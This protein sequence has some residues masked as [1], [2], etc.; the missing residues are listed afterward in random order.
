MNSFSKDVKYNRKVVGFIGGVEMKA[1]R[2]NNLTKIYNK[3][4]VAIKDISLEI[5]EG[6]I[7]GYLGPNGSGKTTTINILSTSIPQTSGEAYIYD[8]KVGKDNNEIRKIISVVPQKTSVNWF[9]TVYQNI[10]VFASILNYSKKEGNELI[11]TLLDRFDLKEYL[12]QPLDDLSGGQIK[13]VELVRALLY[14]P[15]ILF[16]D[17]P[18]I[19][20]DPIGVEMLVSYFK[21]LSSEG[22]T[23]FLATNEISSVEHILDEIVFIYRGRLISHTHYE[24]FLCKYGG[25]RKVKIDYEGKLDDK[26]INF[27]KAENKIK[28]KELNPLQFEISSSY[29][30]LLLPQIQ[31]MLINSN[32]LIKDVQIDKPGLREAFINLA[33]KKGNACSEELLL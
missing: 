31:K 7:I 4:T 23:I 27:L 3:K 21:K 1:L 9:L 15:K 13:R 28:I 32:C 19:G 10:E 2:L 8:Y 22:T 5:E 16:V 20:L 17:E 14:K 30:D 6:K 33:N 26:I 25:I 11:H 24:D 12:N 18:T 29:A